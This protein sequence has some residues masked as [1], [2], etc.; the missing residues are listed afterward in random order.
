MGKYRIV[1]LFCCAVFLFS[2]NKKREAALP[3]AEEDVITETEIVV[4]DTVSRTSI[5]F[6]LG[7][8]HSPYNQYYALANHYYRLNP[9]DKTEIVIDSFVSIKEVCDY[10]KTHPAKNDRPY[11]LINLVSHGNEFL[12]L[13]TLVYPYGPRAS[14]K[15]ILKA[16][17]DSVFQPLDTTILDQKSLIYLHGCAVG[18]NQELLNSLAIAFNSKENGVRVKASRLFEYYSYL[19]KNKNP[20]S[21]RHYFART[22]YAFY[23]PDSIPDEQ[24]FADRFAD[25]YPKDRVNWMEGVQRRFQPNPS[26]IYHFS[27]IVPAVWEDLYEDES[28]VPS[29]NSHRKRKEWMDNNPGFSEMLDQTNIPFNFFQIM[30]Y[31]HGY[32]QKSI[33]Y[34]GL[35]VKARA[36]VMCLIQPLLAEEDSLKAELVAYQPGDEDPDYFRFSEITEF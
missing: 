36:G 8:D 6:I 4:E 27:F 35:R 28:L 10:L 22:W 31:K 18:N 1:W 17:A 15:T 3:P 20:Q 19:S 11:G 7:E 32:K 13:R 5:T 29:V 2:C 9:E 16:A 30:F 12:D 23:H 21:I 14:S 26:E 25:R 24:G 34:H 33:V